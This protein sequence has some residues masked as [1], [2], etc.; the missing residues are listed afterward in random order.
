MEKNKKLDDELYRLKDVIKDLKKSLNDQYEKL[1]SN[2]V[3]AKNN[4]RKHEHMLN[5]ERKRCQSLEEKLQHFQKQIVS[6]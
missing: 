4:G 2:D 1:Q 3:M 6:L 5:E